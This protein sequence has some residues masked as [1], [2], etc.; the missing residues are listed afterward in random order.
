M[1]IKY[2]TTD[3][4][5]GK[6]ILVDRDTSKYNIEINLIIKDDI[7]EVGGTYEN[8]LDIKYNVRLAGL[9]CQYN[10]NKPRVPRGL[11]RNILCDLLYQLIKIGKI[12]TT[13][14]ILL[15][16]DYSIDGK[17]IQMYESMSFINKGFDN[18]IL[19]KDYETESQYIKTMSGRGAVMITT[20]YSLLLWGL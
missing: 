12:K 13:D 14:I 2:K 9:Y 11:T 17:L 18:S 7:Y 10:I 1:D 4:I 20:V 15:E 5:Y 6:Q 16:A 19:R 3:D 8:I